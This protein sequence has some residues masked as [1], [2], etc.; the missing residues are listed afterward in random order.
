[1]TVMS[2][3]P[4]ELFV[5]LFSVLFDLYGFLFYRRDQILDFQ[6]FNT[7]SHFKAA[8][9]EQFHI[10]D[11]HFIAYLASVPRYIRFLHLVYDESGKVLLLL[12]ILHFGCSLYHKLYNT[13]IVKVSYA[14]LLI[15]DLVRF[16]GELLNL[17]F[18]IRRINIQPEIGDKC[19]VI[20]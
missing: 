16:F 3:L 12:T 7:I 2:F 10:T 20:P 11:Y 19:K 8:A 17:G 14:A 6:Y 18:R 15:R 1:M 5:L 9:G 13:A 4:G